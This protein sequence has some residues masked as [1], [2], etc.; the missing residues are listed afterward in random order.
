LNDI[1]QVVH[2]DGLEKAEVGEGNGAALEICLLCPSK[3]VFPAPNSKENSI[4][5]SLR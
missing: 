1:R 3:E 4:C 2:H 5:I